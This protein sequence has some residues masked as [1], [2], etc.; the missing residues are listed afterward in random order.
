[1]YNSQFSCQ[2]S[3][4]G[5]PNDRHELLKLFSYITSL[6][7]HPTFDDLSSIASE[8]SACFSVLV[9]LLTCLFIG[10]W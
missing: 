7:Q 1:M 6:V 5:Q 4:D 3:T 9:R 10:L 8:V 2:N